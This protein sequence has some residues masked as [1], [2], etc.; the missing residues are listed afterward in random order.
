V[1]QHFDFADRTRKSED[2]ANVYLTFIRSVFDLPEPTFGK[3][4]GNYVDAGTQ[5][6][7]GSS[8]EQNRR[9]DR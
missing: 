4:Q 9:R 2:L 7:P 3:P 1:N 8:P 6:V 5:I